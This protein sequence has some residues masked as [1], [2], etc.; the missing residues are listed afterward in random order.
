MYVARS[1]LVACAALL[2][3]PQLAQA[4]AVKDAAGALRHCTGLNFGSWDEHSL[5][6]FLLDRGI[7]APASN[8]EKLAQLAK[9]DCEE[10]ARNFE[11]G[12]GSM[13]KIASQD[14]STAL[15]AASSMQSAVSSMQSSASVEAKRSYTQVQKGAK[16]A[17]SM[18]SSAMSSASSTVSKGGAGVGADAS[19]YSASASAALSD[20][21]DRA[22][23]KLEDS[24]DYA[25]SQWSVDELKKWLQSHGVALPQYV[26][27]REEL[28]KMIREPYT[29]AHQSNP[30]ELFSTDYLHNWLVSH[31]YIESNA[32]KK[33]HEY[34]DLAKRYYYS[35]QDSVYDTWK[36]SELY[37]WLYGHGYAK[38]KSSLGE[39][40]DHYL[41][42]IRNKYSEATDALWE[43][44]SDNDMQTYLVKHGYLKSDAQKKR[45]ELVQLMQKHASDA[46][47]NAHEYVSWS[48]ARL[49]AL[50]RNYGFPVNKLP[51]SRRELLRL[52]RAYYKPSTVSQ[53]RSSIQSGVDCL[54][55]S[56][57][58][59]LGVNQSPL[60]LQTEKFASYASD[61]S[62]SASSFANSV[63]NEL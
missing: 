40:R 30:Y 35:V 42:L 47:A 23:T 37:D 18:A 52:V 22:W 26:M 4:N 51:E 44:W 45:D 1:L 12:K 9:K 5:R 7:V 28:L 14:W 36:D 3:A 41:N 43:G 32:Q 20:L 10:L 34:V 57:Y 2:A 55:N 54:K 53:L 16:N 50:L 8:S 6:A 61:A 19:R 27:T 13:R 11:S 58:R 39:T 46:S 56:V 25:Y 63:R 29:K 31:G 48:D 33:R 15:S 60:G 62:K 24:K 21:Y 59:F 38:S 17:A 49:R